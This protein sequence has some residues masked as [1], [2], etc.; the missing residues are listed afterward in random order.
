LDLLDGFVTVNG[1][2]NNDTVN[3]NDQLNPAADTYTM[4]VTTLT[5]PNFAGLRYTGIENFVL[6]AE[7]GFNV[8]NILRTPLTMTTTIRRNVGTVNVPGTTGPLII[9]P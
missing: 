6:N 2:L 7:T 4:N 3:V 8:F 9:L 1:G 5:R